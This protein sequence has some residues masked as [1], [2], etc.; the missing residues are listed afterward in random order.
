MDIVASL[1]HARWECKYHL[2]FIPKYRLKVLY[3]AL[4]EHLGSVFRELASQKECRVEEGHLCLDHVQSVDL[5][6]SPTCSVADRGFYQRQECHS[7]RANLHGHGGI[8]SRP[9]AGM[10]R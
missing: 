4:R 10:K 5:N 2:V 9:W 7:Y 8:T 3:G 6:S 1:S